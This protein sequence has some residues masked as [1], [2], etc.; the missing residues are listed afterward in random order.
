MSDETETQIR[1]ERP[2]AALAPTPGA[3][4]RP[5]FAYFDVDGTLVSST[6]VHVLADVLC[7]GRG[8]AG[9]AVTRTRILAGVPRMAA[10]DARSRARF[11]EVF[12]R[13]YAG[14]P[15]RRLAT[16][17]AG[18][19]DDLLM[20][21]LYEGAEAMLARARRGGLEPVMVSCSPEILL[22]AFAARLGV[23]TLMANRMEFRDGIATGRLLPPNVDGWG[24]LALVRAHAR[25]TGVDPSRS[26]AVSDHA[27]DLPLLRAT[28]R[29]VVVNPG[30]TLARE[31]ER[32]G[33]PVVL[34]RA[35]RR[36]GRSAHPPP[37]DTGGLDLAALPESLPRGGH[38]GGRIHRPGQGGA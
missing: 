26:V 11:N 37:A 22:R 29:A 31:A 5:G 6:V 20:P 10:I 25:A 32:R 21:A 35:R 7:A 18:L 3:G 4:H 16:L 8:A 30:R 38:D 2:P 19:A 36:R 17:G 23:A 1:P 33:W 12:F 27:S 15:E 34:L 14:L 9:R 13:R 24:K 28:G